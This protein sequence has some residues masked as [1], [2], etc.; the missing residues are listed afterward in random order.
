MT[1]IARLAA[2]MLPLA[3]GCLL[4]AAPMAMASSSSGYRG[5]IRS[6][7]SG[8]CLDVHHAS[9]AAG[10]N[11]DQWPCTGAANQLWSIQPVNVLGERAF[12]IVNDDGLCLG[13]SGGPSNGSGAVQLGCGDQEQIG[14]VLWSEVTAHVRGVRGTLYGFSNELG[15]GEC[16]CREMLD[17]ARVSRRWGANVI[18][19]RYNGGLNQFWFG[20]PSVG[21]V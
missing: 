5:E 8:L 12:E 18:E 1:Q 6:D 9:T 15:S 10:A 11:V 3:L 19:W 17:V 4:M 13:V 2:K 14:R 7:N 21:V 20:A 16:G